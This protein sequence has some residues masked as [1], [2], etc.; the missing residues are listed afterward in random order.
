MSNAKIPRQIAR[1]IGV[2]EDLTEAY[3]TIKDLRGLPEAFQESS[4][5][6]RLVEQ[7]LRAAKSPAKSVDTADDVEVLL[8]ARLDDCEEKADKLLEILQK[9]SG[10][11]STIIDQVALLRALKTNTRRPISM[12]SLEALSL[13]GNIVTFVQFAVELF[14]GTKQISESASRCLIKVP[15]VCVPLM[16]PSCELLA[17][18]CQTDC[19]ELL[20]ILSGLDVKGQVWPGMVEV[21][22]GR[23]NVTQQPFHNQWHMRLLALSSG[24]SV[25]PGQISEGSVCIRFAQPPLETRLKAALK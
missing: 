22:P 24:G 10:K 2:I 3:D 6:L 15:L 23:Y 16:K 7:T 8:G 9:I 18:A 1:L 5:C 13:A 19:G 12:E 17:K 14:N 25:L 4:K 21:V 20:G 11:S